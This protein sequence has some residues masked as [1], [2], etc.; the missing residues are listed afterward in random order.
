MPATEIN[1]GAFLL[2]CRW[3]G[4]RFASPRTMRAFAASLIVSLVIGI[5]AWLVVSAFLG[6]LLH[7]FG[8]R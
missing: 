3:R 6:P 8:L 4:I 2:V 5:T 1:L 7:Y